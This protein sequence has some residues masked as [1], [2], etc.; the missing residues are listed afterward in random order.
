MYVIDSSILDDAVAMDVS[1]DLAQRNITN[2]L[3][4]LDE[5]RKGYNMRKEQVRILAK[6]KLTVEYDRE[7]TVST[8]E[9]MM[10]VLAE[11]KQMVVDSQWHDNV[12]EKG[13]QQVYKVIGQQPG[14]NY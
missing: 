13:W 1:W 2:S 9:T 10:E 11:M 6:R 3:D 12:I 5:L 8:I 4:I 7:V 14:E